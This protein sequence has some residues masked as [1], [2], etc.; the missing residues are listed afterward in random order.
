MVE[1][2]PNCEFADIGVILEPLLESNLAR[3]RA[4]IGKG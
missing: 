2:G 4:Q 1:I 3:N